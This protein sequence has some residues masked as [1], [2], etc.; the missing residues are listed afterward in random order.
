MKKF[1]FSL[2]SLFLGIVLFFWLWN[3]I[4]WQEIRNTFLHLSGFEIIFLIFLSFLGIFLGTIRWKEI[5]KSKGHQ[6]S[7]KELCGH[8]LAGF[9]ITYLA[10]V[11]VLGGPIFRGYVL[12]SR[13][14]NSFA[15]E[16]GIAVSFI[17][18]IFEYIF[19]WLMIFLA[20]TL[21]FLF[22]GLPF[23]SS[24]LG[25]LIAL[26]VLIGAIFYYFLIKKKS[27]IKLLFRVKEQNHGLKIEK[28]ILAF[29]EIKNKFFQRALF[30]SIAKV[31]V[32]FFQYW[33]LLDFLGRPISFIFGLMVLGISTLSMAPP[34]SA[35]FGT[36]DLGSAILFEKIGIGRGAGIAFASLVRGLNLIVAISGIGF[37]VKIGFDALQHNLLKKIRE[38][39]LINNFSNENK[40]N[41]K[42]K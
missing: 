21:L 13:Q 7:L 8:Y 12:N 23:K 36:H 11:V 20:I 42:K 6:F 34:I 1:I 29:F 18:E 24:Q 39:S 31:L 2:I 38:N 22:I 17:D 9:A 15:L 35:D 33:I 37:L 19:A 10:P 28:E 27:L 40:N 5:L 26:L 30:L 16:R 3:E 4:G 41:K 32:R 25:I 14:K